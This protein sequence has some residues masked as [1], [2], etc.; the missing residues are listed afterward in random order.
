MLQNQFFDDVGQSFQGGSGAHR[1]EGVGKG[2]P[3]DDQRG[4]EGAASETVGVERHQAS[5]AAEVQ[6]AVTTVIPGD[7]SF[8]ARQAIQRVKS[9][10]LAGFWVEPRQAVAGGHP[11]SPLVVVQDRY[12]LV[13]RQSVLPVDDLGRAGG[14]I[15]ADQSGKRGQPQIALW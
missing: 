2:D 10:Y 3:R 4:L 6:H 9:P 13:V 12:G 7:H 5:G 14:G 8:V 15:E 1:Q 11:V